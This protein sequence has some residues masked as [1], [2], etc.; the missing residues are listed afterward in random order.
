MNNNSSRLFTNINNNQTET[1]FSQ[2]F[3]WIL[4]IIS[5]VTIG[6]VIYYYAQTDTPLQG[7]TY[8]S[9]DILHPDPIFNAKADNLTQCIDRCK[10]DARCDG[11]TYDSETGQCLGQGN[12]RL[13]NDNENYFAWVKP[14]SKSKKIGVVETLVSSVPPNKEHIVPTGS[15]PYPPFP[16]QFAISFW[17]E[18]NDFYHNFG[19]WR[20]IFH[21]GESHNQKMKYRSWEQ[22][23]NDLPSQTPGLW[24][25]PFQNNLR[26]VYSTQQTLKGGFTKE[27]PSEHAQAPEDKQFLVADETRSNLPDQYVKYME[28]SDL[29][30]IP[31]GKPVFI[32]FVFH[33]K[34]IEYYLDG[35]LRKT[36]ILEGSP[37]IPSGQLFIKQK[38]SYNG[39]LDDLKYHIDAIPFRKVQDIYQQG[40][41]RL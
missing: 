34:S 29:G 14:A 37:V 11:I 35:K 9:E 38:E 7:Q 6:Y 8:Y 4:L 24:M 10:L 17:V 15:I 30:E 26:L 31:I 20:N 36:F 12:G 22:V 41:P 32:C 1:F 40:N 16:N 33:D 18:I 19:Y 25:A 13:R 28:Y 5:L 3:V 21:R 2:Y 23:I 27:R 39:Y